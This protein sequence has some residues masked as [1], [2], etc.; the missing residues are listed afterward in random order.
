M[1]SEQKREEQQKED[2]N[3]AVRRLREFRA[4]TK[5]QEERIANMPKSTEGNPFPDHKEMTNP[6]KYSN[7]PDPKTLR[8]NPNGG[9]DY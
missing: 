1:R 6:E 2:E 7:K 9:C 8:T 3:P 5:E 4:K